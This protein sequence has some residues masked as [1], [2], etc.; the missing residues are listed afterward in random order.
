MGILNPKKRYDR[1]DDNDPEK[2]VDP[3]LKKFWSNVGKNSVPRKKVVKLKVEGGKVVIEGDLAEQG[4]LL[5]DGLT[6]REKLEQE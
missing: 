3:K 6:E 5:D 1:E 2:P 4:V